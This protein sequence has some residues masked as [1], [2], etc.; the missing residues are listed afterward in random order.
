MDD[1]HHLTQKQLAFRWRISQ[2]TLEAW[3]WRGDGPPYLKIG[4]RCI[5]RLV[6]V[7]SFEASHLRTRTIEGS[8]GKEAVSR[9]AP[10]RVPSRCSRTRRPW[11]AG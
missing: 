10:I 4:G 9:I 6:D 2:R 7:K 5:Y 3:R 1:D 8:E 11:D